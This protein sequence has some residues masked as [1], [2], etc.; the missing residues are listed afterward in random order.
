MRTA[1]IILGLCGLFLSS[2]SVSQPFASK[3]PVP[4]PSEPL[5]TLT[6]TEYISPDGDS[7]LKFQYEKKPFSYQLISRDTGHVLATAK[8]ALEPHNLDRETI[9]AT[10]EVTFASDQSG[11]LIHD[12]HSD[13]SPNPYYILIQRKENSPAYRVIY[14]S[15]PTEHINTPGEFDFLYPGVKALTKN[16]VTF[17]YYSGKNTRTISISKL[18]QSVELRGAEQWP[19]EQIETHY[20]Q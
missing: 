9:R 8:T 11:V 2:C 4:P 7:V 14:L 17:Y 13:A 5:H 20:K 18:L 19:S 12:D 1:P 10:I 3:I 16:D 6:S 15:P